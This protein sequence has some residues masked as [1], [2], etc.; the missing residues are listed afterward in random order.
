MYDL[1]SSQL[2]YDVIR[3]VALAFVCIFLVAISIPAFIIM[4]SDIRA[5]FRKWR[6]RKKAKYSYDEKPLQSVTKQDYINQTIY[7]SVKKSCSG[8]YKCCKCCKRCSKR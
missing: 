4:V 5:H 1:L 3:V 6:S 8:N 2:V 7:L